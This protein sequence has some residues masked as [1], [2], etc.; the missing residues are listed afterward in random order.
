[1][2]NLTHISIASLALVVTAPL[3]IAADI[4]DPP[5]VE[6]IPEVTHI[7]A[8]GGWYLRGDFGYAHMSVTHV[9]KQLSYVD[10]VTGDVVYSLDNFSSASLDEAWVLGGGIGYQANATFRFDGTIRHVFDADFDGDS[11][12]SGPGYLCSLLDG[13]ADNAT[14]D[15][16]TSVDTGSFSATIAMANAYADL[17]T[18]AGFTP[19]V[20]AGVGGAYTHWSDLIN[21]SQCTGGGDCTNGTVDYETDFDGIHGRKN[22]WRFAYSAH[23]G[24]SYDLT[25]N[26]KID[27][28]YTFTHISG[29]DMYGFAGG[30]GVQGH[31]GDIKLHEVR[32][33]LRYSFR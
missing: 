28:G 6:V 7:E 15:T 31:H 33:G 20:G 23:A 13:N 9:D 14:V 3:A 27:A 32:A 19:Y 16:C 21:D 5:Y 24:A 30:A 2:S 18:F 1:M 11:S 10:T 8:A 25:R 17:G 29:G 4:I 26:M 12:T 22:G